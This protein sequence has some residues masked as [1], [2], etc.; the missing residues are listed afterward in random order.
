MEER[1]VKPHDAYFLTGV[2][3]CAFS[4]PYAGA[5]LIV[6]AITWYANQ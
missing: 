1:G 5:F 6:C 3:L 2:V 4:H